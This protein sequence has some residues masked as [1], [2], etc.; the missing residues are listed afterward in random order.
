M[1]HHFLKTYSIIALN[2]ETCSEPKSF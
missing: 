2:A 1:Q